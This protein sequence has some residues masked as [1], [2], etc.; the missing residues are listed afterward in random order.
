MKKL[1]YLLLLTFSVGNAQNIDQLHQEI[2]A[3][4]RNAAQ[5]RMQ[6][7]PMAS[8]GNYDVIFNRIDLILNNLTSSA[9]SGEVTTYY[10]PNSNLTSM[11]FDFTHTIPVQS[12]TQRGANLTF[13]QA[14][15]VLTVNF[16]S[17]QTS[18]VL[19]SI[20]ITYSGNVPAT[21]LDS[22]T[23]QT[24][25]ANNTPIIFTLSEPYGAK[26]WWPC[27]QDLI[28]KI[29][30]I[31]VILH[32]PATVN[33]ENM[34]GVSNGLLMSESTT[35]SVKT[36]MWKSNYPITAYLVAFTITNYEEFSYNAGVTQPFTIT[37]YAYAENLTSAQSTNAGDVVSVMNFY[38]QKFVPYPFKNE[39]YAQVQFGWGGGMEHQ[40][41]SFINSF[42]RSLVA[43]ELAHQW[44]GDAVT[45][46]SWHDIWINEGFATYSEAL[47]QEHLD[48]QT[49]FDNWKRGANN[50]II[51]ETNGAVYVTDT[52]DIDRIFDWRLS[53]TKGAMVLN[54]LRLKLGDTD[55]FQGI[56]TYVTAKNNGFATISDF[57]VFMATQSGQNLDEFF[58]DWIYG[59][60]YPTYDITIN[61]TGTA[62]QYEIIVNQTTSDPSVPFYEMPLPFAFSDGINVYNTV[63]DHTSSGQTFTVDV[64]FLPTNV[65][66]DPHY[67]IVKGTTTLHTTLSNN[68]VLDEQFKIYPNPTTDFIYIEN[69]SQNQINKVSIMSMNGQIIFSI[70][71][72]FDKI[73]I[74]NLAKG[75]YFVH[76]KTNKGHFV[77]KIIKK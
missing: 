58:A 11:E 13:S 18:G 37:N 68:E 1:L 40:T 76:I 44:F 60:G 12:V 59:E 65:A 15:N 2:V 6:H 49:A 33:G 53:Y 38:E 43:H 48:G 4:E 19:D 39:R 45:C 7:R 28:D 27:K 36:S 14:N 66:F 71:K 74:S 47:V 75:N 52:T 29:D 46:G 67:D 24:H 23:V 10:K 62:N 31:E 8:T 69:K 22:Y 61:A 72:Y 73:D 54:M 21:G 63:L 70:N 3:G 56:Q 50:V 16:P 35:G 5:A 26:D 20:K 17:Q 25:G 9:L 51:A 32:Y 30:S 64:G 34:V 55:F 41:A 42:N 57:K 77:Q